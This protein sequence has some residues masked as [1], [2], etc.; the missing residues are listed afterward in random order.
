MKRARILVAIF[1]SQLGN[2]SLA[3]V[4]LDAAQK[5]LVAH[6]SHKKRLNGQDATLLQV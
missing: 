2:T 4:L 5:Y 3:A 6:I 1:P